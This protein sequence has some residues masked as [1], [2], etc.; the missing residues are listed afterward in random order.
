MY[1]PDK[2]RQRVK[3]WAAIVGVG[4][5]AGLGAVTIIDGAE[6]TGNADTVAVKMSSTMTMT[7][8]PSAPETPFASPTVKAP[9]K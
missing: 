6:G 2:R 4:A 9:H 3:L 8:P 5:M 7:T 1:Q